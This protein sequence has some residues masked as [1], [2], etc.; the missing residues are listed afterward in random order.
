MKKKLRGHF[1][2]NSH[3]D[4]EWTLPFQKHRHLLVQFLDRLLEIFDKVPEYTFLLDSQTIPLEDYLAIRPENEGRLKKLVSGGRLVIGPW[5]TAPDCNTISGESIV[6]NLVLGERL[7]GRFGGGMKL[8]YTPFGFGQVSQLPQIYAG[9]G[10]D[11]IFFYRGITEYESP[12][13]EFAWKG[14]DGTRATCSRFGERSRYN[15]FMEVWRPVVCGGGMFDRIFDWSGGGVPF[16]RTSKGHEYDHY[17][18]QRPRL[19]IDEDKIDAAWKKL[20]ELE[21][22]HYLTC[23]IPLMQ[24][25]DT[26]MPDVLEARLLEKI[27]QRL[28][29][30]EKIFFSTL[31]D[32]VRELKRALKG[33]K[34]KIFKGEMRHPGPPSVYVTELEHTL[35]ARIRQKVKQSGAAALLERW[36]EPFS[37]LNHILGRDYPK[38]YLDIAWKNLLQSHPHDTVAGCGVDQLERDSSY[39]LDQVK[40]ISDV[41]IDDSLG[42]LQARIDTTNVSKDRIL[43]TVFNPSPHKRTETVEAFLDVPYN[44]DIGDFV[45]EDV[46]G[47]PVTWDFVY[48]KPVEK[49]VRNNTDV[50]MAI[51]GW[52][53]KL[54]ILAEEVPA[55]G[56]RSFVLRREKEFPGSMKR[57]A[58]SATMLENEYLRATVN[59]NGTIELMDKQ[60]GSVYKGL[61]YFEDSGE[62]GTGWESRP[63]SENIVVSS[64]GCPVEIS[65]K[66]NT[67]L[68]GT[69][70]VRYRMR[71]PSG[72]I[73]DNAHE[74]TRRGEREEDLAI[75]T[76]FTL[77][78]GARR[79][80]C[81]TRFEN[82]AKNHRLRVFFPTGLSGAGESAAETPFDVVRRPIPRGP[83]HPYSRTTNPQQPCLRFAD[84][85]D[86]KSGLAALTKGI[87]EYEVTDDPSRILALTLLRSFE[88]TLCTVTYRWERMPNQELSQQ[89]GPHELEYS[90]YPHR[91]DW[92]QGSVMEEAE[93][94]TLPMETAQSTPLHP[95]E[96]K[97][98]RL[99]PPVYGFL[100][101]APSELVMSSL[102]RAEGSNDTILRIYNPTERSIQGTIRVPVKIRNSSLVNMNEGEIKGVSLQARGRKSFKLRVGAKKVISIRLK[103]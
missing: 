79:L 70:R 20:L 29:P 49:T 87:H 83:D 54:H 61:H 6:R 59:S 71:I 7:A 73:H 39:R 42:W 16:K 74:Y 30:G 78:A 27:R 3:L 44:L 15:F 22:P 35:S 101:I 51:T 9:F 31:P 56:Y 82:R 14:A 26:T 36:A 10:I 46:K 8:G 90:L 84:V 100:E 91:G 2:P 77:R 99:F 94:F 96:A 50:T 62:R 63:P 37:T 67:P 93:H 25:M 75:E 17:F 5:Y 11:F 48:R 53:T 65:L 95:E 80:D 66:E 55:L 32:Y 69:I 34:L 81:R 92:I 1:I 24:G 60:T 19:G 64:L 33:K 21:R 58:P 68:S 4:R 47:K 98:E 28:G 97:G 18:I 76:F 85:S 88:V 43:I 72:L 86:G 102:K 23:V 12:A 40:G 45:I 103:F 57:I 89:I 38:P 52:M 13:A 41:L